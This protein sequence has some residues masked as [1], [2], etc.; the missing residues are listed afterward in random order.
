MFTNDLKFGQSYEAEA[1]Q[2]YINTG[3]ILIDN[4]INK[5]C[6]RD[7]DFIVSKGDENLKIEVKADRLAHKTGNIC[8]EYECNGKP[9]GIETTKADN[10]I[11]YIVNSNTYNIP[12]KVI[13]EYIKNRKYIR[14]VKGGDRYASNMYL[15]KINLFNNY[16]I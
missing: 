16:L 15:F 5:G 10:Y 4:S 7:Y 1:I 13:K 14:V 3:F 12:V 2:Y 11:Y 8:I 6:F 9:S